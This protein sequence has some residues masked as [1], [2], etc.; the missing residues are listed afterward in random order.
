VSTTRSRDWAA[1]NRPTF[2]GEVGAAI[3]TAIGKHNQEQEARQTV[4]D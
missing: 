4:A 3:M 1:E 2:I